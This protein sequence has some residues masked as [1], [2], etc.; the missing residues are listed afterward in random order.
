MFNIT[1]LMKY[2]MK[3]S[4]SEVFSHKVTKRQNHTNSSLG[5]KF[6]F[7]NIVKSVASAFYTLNILV[8]FTY[9]A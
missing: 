5:M 7:L 4:R 6:L 2:T 9:I 8:D 3:V 1:E